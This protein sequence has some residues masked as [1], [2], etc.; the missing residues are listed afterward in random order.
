MTSRIVVLL[1]L[2]SAACA[3]DA[4]VDARRYQLAGV[5]VGPDGGSSRIVIAHE[6]IEGLM[7]AMSMAFDIEG[8]SLNG[9]D[10]IVATL[11]LSDSRSWL[12]N[13]R[14]TGRDG[15]ASADRGVAGRATAGA[16]VPDLLLVSQNGTQ[17]TLRDPAGRVLILTFL[18]TRCPMPDMCPLM[19]RHLE[20]VRQRAN[21][22]GMGS[23]LVLL[24][25]TLDPVFDT[26]AVLRT[27]GESVLKASNRFDQWTLATGPVGQ[28]EEA[29]RFFGVG[30][31]AEGG[32]VTHTLTTAVI[33]GDGRV[34]RTFGSNS[35]RADDLFDVVRGAIMRT[36][37][38]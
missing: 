17:V 15:A 33:G 3:A 19:V 37:T 25:V 34:I 2:L 27:Y 10:R 12:E 9:G 18:Y 36:P 26:P 24:G 5:V 13:V 4:R 21:D 23:R 6:A 35:W 31:R 8:A 29:A 14:V 7:P 38:Q 16:V 30:Y 32:F 20:T 28:V 22:A 1:S 11:A